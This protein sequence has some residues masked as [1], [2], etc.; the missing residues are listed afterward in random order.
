MNRFDFDF[1]LQRMSVIVRDVQTDQLYVYAKGSVEAISSCCAPRCRSSCSYYSQTDDLNSVANEA[2]KYASLGCYVLA[3]A[4]RHLGPCH[5]QSVS[6]SEVETNLNMLGLLLARNE[7][8]ARER[9]LLNLAGKA[10]D[11]NS[12]NGF[13]FGQHYHQNHY[14]R[15]SLHCLLHCWSER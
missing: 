9:L 10:R 4:F 1:N 2:K 14:R 8:I 11:S 5:V 6:R 3:V 7:V 13:T 15:Y 12:N